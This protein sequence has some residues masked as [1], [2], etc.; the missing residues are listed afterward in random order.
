MY[1]TF[2]WIQSIRIWLSEDL[3]SRRVIFNTDQFSQS[4]WSVGF[5]YIGLPLCSELYFIHTVRWC[6]RAVQKDT[7]LFFL[8]YCCTY[9]LIRLVSFKVLPSTVDTPFPA[10]FS[11]SGTRPGTCFVGWREGPVSN[12]LLSPLPSEIGDLLGWTSTLGTGKSPQ[13]PN[14]E[15]SGAGA[16]Q[17]Y[18]AS[19]KIH[20]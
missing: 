9:N 7:E 11:S 15:S 16:R 5:F 13:G 18:L 10:F 6:T 4:S 20:G 1:S 12:F 17:S 2:D 19:P 14:L 3:S 8:I